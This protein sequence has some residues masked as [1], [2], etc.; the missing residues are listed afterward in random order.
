MADATTDRGHRKIT[1]QSKTRHT[2][3][4]ETTAILTGGQGTM[5]IQVVETET[6]P[7]ANGTETVGKRGTVAGEGVEARRTHIDG[8]HPVLVILAG[9]LDDQAE[10]IATRLLPFIWHLL[11]YHCMMTRKALKAL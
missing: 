9:T 1:I 8:T 3:E 11:A 2:N 5:G 7:V 6:D 4:N 10:E